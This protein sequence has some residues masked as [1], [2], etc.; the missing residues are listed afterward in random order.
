MMAYQNFN[1]T[2]SPEV[3]NINNLTLSFAKAVG[4]AQDKKNENLV[5][6]P[7]NIAM[8]L[9]MLSKA[10]I[11]DTKEELA[12]TLFNVSADDLDNEI[13]KLI[14]L[15][16]KVL[17]ANKAQVTLKT[18][19]ALWSNEDILTL[20]KS[21]AG[22][23]QKL[24]SA[25]INGESFSDPSVV[26]KI[27]GW[28]TKNTNG[29]INQIIDQ[30]EDDDFVILASALY[31]KGDWTSKF[32]KKNTEDRQFNLDDGNIVYTPTMKKNFSNKNDL[33]YLDNSDYEALSMTFGERDYSQN[34]Q[35]TMRLVLVRPKDET[36]AARDWIAAQSSQSQHQWL[37]PHSYD[38]V[39]GNVELPKMEMKS[40]YDLIP[41]LKDMGVRLVFDPDYADL[42]EMAEENDQLHVNKVQ[43]D[44][45]L[46]V[47][48]NGGE[49]AAVTTIGVVRTT[50]V[51]MPPKRIDIKFDRSFAFALQ[52]IQSGAVIFAG[53]VNEPSNDMHP[54]PQKK[55]LSGPSL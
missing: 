37:D 50:S 25:E 41:A 44:T 49:A 31:F 27:N 1:S 2:F 51:Q 29:L 16:T 22:Q 34:K 3:K 28:A 36:I 30:L 6:S 9:S 4:D 33:S 40:R 17:D 19:N 26:G 32:D 15:N 48:E 14:A 12:Q 35:P 7:Y 23:I 43:H 46:K 54:A 45:V 5:L 18:A 11:G 53:A 10:A 21:F 38:N 24:F 47:D 52:D 39:V 55:Q 42:S 13:N 8:A 20:K